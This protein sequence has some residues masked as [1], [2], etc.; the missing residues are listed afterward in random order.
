MYML[1]TALAGGQHTLDPTPTTADR[2]SHFTVSHGEIDDLYVSRNGK[3]AFE[4]MGSPT[5][6]DYDTVFWARFNNSL[7][8]SNISDEIAQCDFLR[9][10][11]RE[12]NTF[13]W[14]TLFEVDPNSLTDGWNFFRYD[15]TARSNTNY[16]Y[17]I[18][19]VSGGIEGNLNIASVHSCFQGIYLFDPGE[20]GEM[21]Y[22][23][24]EYQNP[25]VRNKEVSTITTLGSKYPYTVSNALANYD[26]GTV[27]GLFARYDW[28]YG[29]FDFENNVQ[30]R[31]DFMA[32]LTNG[33]EKLMKM[34]N[35]RIWLCRPTSNPAEG[36]FGDIDL[37]TVGTVSFDWVE[38]ANAQ[39]GHDLY[40]H[41]FIECDID[42]YSI[43]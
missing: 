2:V 22:A 21:Y 30:Y 38:N 33:R 5:V 36:T 32:F 3:T 20:Y 19:P 12:A 31:D 13:Q 24:V 29:E 10:K 34:G 7:I 27:S 39:L 17:A 26:S 14:I 43:S 35:G 40:L 15:R 28:D 25:K 9:I 4:C 18:V 37:D 41:G 42:D 16:D 6:W 8:S 23:L 1:G 11:R